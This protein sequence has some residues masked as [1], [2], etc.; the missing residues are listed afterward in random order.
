MG[1]CR[2]EGN[3]FQVVQSGKGNRDINQTFL[4]WNGYNLSRKWPMY[5]A[6]AAY[7]DRTRLLFNNNY[8]FKRHH[9]MTF[10]LTKWVLKQGQREEGLYLGGMGGL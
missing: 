8:V 3:G 4:V 9:K 10:F 6:V 7:A 2:C 5:I 1:M